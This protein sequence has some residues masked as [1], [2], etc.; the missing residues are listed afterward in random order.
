MDVRTDRQGLGVLERT[1]CEQLLDRAP[2]GR[3]AFLVDGRPMVLPVNHVRRGLLLGFRCAPGSKLDAA[4]ETGPVAF[5]VDA[6]DADERTA[7][8]VVATG[9]ARLATPIERAHLEQVPHLSWAD[10]VARDHWVVVPIARLTGRWLGQPPADVIDLT[11]TPPP[12]GT[13]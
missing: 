5:E 11:A 9:V 7:W 3:L 2:L 1:A 10:A 8:S 4:R 6:F 13:P 12:E